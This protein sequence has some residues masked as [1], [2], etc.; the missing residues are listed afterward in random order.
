[1]IKIRFL[2]YLKYKSGG[3]KQ[4]LTVY[5]LVI[6]DNEMLRTTCDCHMWFSVRH[7]CHQ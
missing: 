4:I 5:N 3:T 6:I 1:M 2:S 7:K